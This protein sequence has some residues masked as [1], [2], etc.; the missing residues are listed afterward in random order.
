MRKTI[1]LLTLTFLILTN[2]ATAIDYNE[3]ENMELDKETIEII[4]E[5]INNPETDN[6]AMNTLKNTFEDEILEITLTETNK[7]FTLI[8]KNGTLEDIKEGTDPEAT[9]KLNMNETL[10]KDLESLENAEDPAQLILDALNSDKIEYQATEKASLKTKIMMFLSK[11]MLSLATLI[12]GI[13]SI[14]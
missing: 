13:I 6:K 9:I 4:K 11:I 14:F 12:K 5:H 7:T 1:I 8:T 3:I 2:T 10:F